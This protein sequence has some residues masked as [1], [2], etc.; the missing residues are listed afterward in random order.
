MQ[1]NL[2][3]VKIHTLMKRFFISNLLK[4]GFFFRKSDYDS[5]L[6]QI[7]P[8]TTFKNKSKTHRFTRRYLVN[9]K[10]TTTCTRYVPNCHRIRGAEQQQKTIPS[11]QGNTFIASDVMLT[12]HIE[13][14]TNGGILQ[15]KDLSITPAPWGVFS[16]DQPIYAYLEVYN[17]AR[18]GNAYPYR[19]EAQLTPRQSNTSAPLSR[20]TRGRHAPKDGVSVSFAQSPQFPHDEANFIIETNG[21][22][23]S[24]YTLTLNITNIG[25]Q[26]TSFKEISITLE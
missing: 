15:H 23:R 19:I 11:Y 1:F 18:Q 8:T 5:T 14:G 12:Y 9:R 10:S 17:L 25:T 7:I 24:K 13:E 2:N 16:A 4:T 3:F 21:Q 22:P 6:A 20:V 26:Q